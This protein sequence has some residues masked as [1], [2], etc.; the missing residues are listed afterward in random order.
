[1]VSI[2]RKPPTDADL[3]ALIERCRA[4]AFTYEP[5]G[6]TK[7]AAPPPG[8]RR[9]A[10][11]RALG[12]GDDVFLRARDALQRW[13]VHEGAGLAVVADGPPAADCMVAMSAPLPI[14]FIDVVCRVV[15]V[16]DEADR[17]S[18]VYGTLA[19]H[20]EQGEES[21]TVWRS[22]DG[23]VAFRIVAV[24][25]PHQLLAKIGAPVA[26]RLQHSATD[27]YLN[28]MASEVTS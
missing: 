13:R 14:G 25:R 16:E 2:R 7:L 24:S 28:A 6:M 1:V 9:D 8:Y 19:V 17:F 18:F 12:H 3:A 21:F 27:R 22:S 20:P 5:L 26:R 11:S 4:D 10:W 15:E 23:D